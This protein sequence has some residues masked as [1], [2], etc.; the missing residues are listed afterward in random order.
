MP[1]EKAIVV[2]VG[3]WDLPTSREK[4]PGLGQALHR[5]TE[6]RMES[7][8]LERRPHLVLG[9]GYQVSHRSPLSLD[10]QQISSPS[11]HHPGY[12]PYRQ[13]RARCRPSD[14]YTNGQEKSCVAYFFPLLYRTT[15]SA[16][17]QKILSLPFPIAVSWEF[18]RALEHGLSVPTPVF[19][20]VLKIVPLKEFG[21]LIWHL[22]H[23]GL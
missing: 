9:S 7:A 20:L 16:D 11:H 23:L 2:T 4:T 10:P 17:R 12:A 13:L 19:G 22:G 1:E 14:R 18:E 5:G 15:V 6:Q 3:D 21:G 8:H